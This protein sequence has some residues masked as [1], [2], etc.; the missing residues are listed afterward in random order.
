MRPF[1]LS[2]TDEPALFL[3]QAG[4]RMPYHTFRRIVHRSAE[5]AGLEINVTPHTFRGGC[6][7]ELIRAVANLYRQGTPGP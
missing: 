6:T 2:Q 5:A 3:N 4:R 7:T 1:L